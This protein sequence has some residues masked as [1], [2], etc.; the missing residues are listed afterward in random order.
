MSNHVYYREGIDALKPEGTTWTR[1]TTNMLYV[2]VGLTGAVWGVQVDGKPAVRIGI[3]RDTPYGNAWKESTG[4]DL[5]QLEVGD[6]QVYGTTNMHEIYRLTGCSTTK[7]EGTGWEQVG[8]TLRHIAVGQGPVLWGV[9][10]A[11]QLWFKV[12]GDGRKDVDEDKDRFWEQSLPTD[13]NMIQLSV[14]RDGHVWA[15]GSDGTV[16]W[17]DGVTTTDHYGTGW[18]AQ[19]KNA[20]T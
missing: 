14:G 3:T 5:R 4:A 2:S 15:V 7:P 10:Y 19:P 18:S 20:D 11:H 8:G 13:K 12:V 1:E 17:R 16:Y 6:C 9:D